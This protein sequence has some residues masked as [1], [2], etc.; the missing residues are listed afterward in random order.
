LEVMERKGAQHGLFEHLAP[1]ADPTKLEDMKARVEDHLTL[2]TEEK[3][4][5]SE[6]LFRDLAELTSEV[7]LRKLEEKDAG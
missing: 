3:E 4:A 6:E 7:L 2:P 5:R 1:H